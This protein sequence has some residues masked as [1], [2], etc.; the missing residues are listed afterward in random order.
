L[1][2][3]GNPVV[4]MREIFAT[5]GKSGHRMRLLNGSKLRVCESVLSIRPR[6][7]FGLAAKVGKISR[8][9]PA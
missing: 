2:V 1:R 9:Q 5:I 6:R 3:V 8:V 7:I 4:G